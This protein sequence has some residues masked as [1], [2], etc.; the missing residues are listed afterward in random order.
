MG[1]VTVLYDPDCGFCRWSAERLRVW[2]RRHALGFEPLGSAHADRL[3]L[4]VPVERRLDSWHVVERD[5]RVWSAGQAVARVLRLLPGGAPLALAA[6]LAP[7]LTDRLYASVARRRSTLGRLL[8][9]QAC[10]VDPSRMATPRGRPEGA[11]DRQ[12]PNTIAKAR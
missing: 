12:S 4:V 5:G 11:T 8:G 10:A 6:E 9:Q 7:G 3:L 2:D 1:R